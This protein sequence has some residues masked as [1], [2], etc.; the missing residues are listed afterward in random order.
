MRT[1]PQAISQDAFSGLRRFSN[2]FPWVD[3]EKI[4]GFF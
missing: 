1:Y 3:D 4:I 2:S